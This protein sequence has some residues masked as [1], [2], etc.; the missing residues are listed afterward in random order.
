M[1]KKVA[2]SAKQ[3]PKKKAPGG[4]GTITGDHG[5][6]TRFSASNQPTPEAKKE[7]HMKRR[8]LKDMLEMTFTGPKGGKLLKAAA[9]YMGIPE[10]EL[11]VEDMLHFR[12]IE[13]AI[14]KSNTFAYMA[15]MDRAYGKPVQPVKPEDEEGFKIKLTI[16]GGKNAGSGN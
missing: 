4:R 5:V 8:M 6:A 9:A 11:T 10:D 2:K 12:Q 16:K 13:R 1:A 14:G 15:V 7:G 3:P